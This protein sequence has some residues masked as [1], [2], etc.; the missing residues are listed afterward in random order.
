[1]NIL[2]LEERP[3]QYSAHG[4]TETQSSYIVPTIPSRLVTEKDQFKHP[5]TLALDPVSVI[6]SKQNV[7]CVI[8][9]IIRKFVK[10]SIPPHE[11]RYKNNTTP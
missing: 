6:K 2:Q 3:P 10:A 8:R 5:T 1:M 4:K 7:L 9:K 11:I